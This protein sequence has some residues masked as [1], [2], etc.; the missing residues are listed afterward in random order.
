MDAAASIGYSAT[1]R[2]R[3]LARRFTAVLAAYVVALAAM[4]GS[5]SVEAHHGG[6]TRC[7]AAN[8][9]PVPDQAPDFDRDHCG[10][11][12]VASSFAPPTG[13][14]FLV[15]AR[16]EALFPPPWADRASLSAQARAGP[17][18]ARAPPDAI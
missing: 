8:P 3:A 2:P 17:G 4:M 18:L 6:D 11:C 15:E 7:L 13:A 1:M 9:S 14:V 10:L 12:A 16:I 5:V